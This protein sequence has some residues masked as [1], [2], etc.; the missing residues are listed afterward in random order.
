MTVCGMESFQSF[1]PYL[2][3]YIRKKIRHICS[4]LQVFSQKAHFFQNNINLLEEKCISA[5]SYGLL[6]EFQ[7]GFICFLSA[8]SFAGGVLAVIVD[9]EGFL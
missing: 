5:W 9:A 4:S 8:L 6:W 3:A 1:S 7:S 2:F